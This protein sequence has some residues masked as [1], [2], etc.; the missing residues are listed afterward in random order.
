MDWKVMSDLQCCIP[1][2]TSLRPA[3]HICYS[4]RSVSALA[5][6]SAGIRTGRDKYTRWTGCK[7]KRLNLHII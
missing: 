2:K 7:R 6:I 3:C 4:D 1:E 5:H